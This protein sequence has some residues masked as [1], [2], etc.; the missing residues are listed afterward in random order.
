MDFFQRALGVF[1][2]P[3]PASVIS[4]ES[5]K[6]SQPAPKVTATVAPPEPKLTAA[7]ETEAKHATTASTRAS[8]AP[9]TTARALMPPALPASPSK[10]VSPEP[11]KTPL[12]AAAQEKAA[13]SSKAVA[14]GKPS[15]AAKTPA[16]KTAPA[17]ATAPKP[18]AGA[19]TANAE[20]KQTPP[21]KMLA[22]NLAPPTV[23]IVSEK[24]GK[25]DAESSMAHNLRGRELIQQGKY[26]EAVDELTAAIDARP[27][28]ALALNARGFAYVLLKD[29]AH[30]TADLDAAIR[31]DP[32]YANAYHNRA[33]ARKATGN[34][35]GAAED[36]SKV[37]ELTAKK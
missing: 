10:A 24:A 7:K 19:T 6:P 32:R 4:A 31:L 26:R 27:D 23:P 3:L 35:A 20:P 8:V 16:V 21:P 33:V 2:Q 18:M 37:Q 28:F 22:K 17:P 29:W 15:A 13:N 5:V 30:A 36:E 11:A 1:S 14:E 34:E 25:V 9:V 12:K